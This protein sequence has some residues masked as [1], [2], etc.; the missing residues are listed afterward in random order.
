MT[1]QRYSE[2]VGVLGFI[3]TTFMSWEGTVWRMV[4]GVGIDMRIS[5]AVQANQTLNSVLPKPESL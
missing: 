3:A 2:G 4:A 1:V 5:D